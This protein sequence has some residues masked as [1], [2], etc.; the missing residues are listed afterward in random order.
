MLSVLRG[1]SF[2]LLWTAGLVSVTGDWVLNAALPF[3]VYEETGSTIATAGMIVA[4]LAPTAL[5]GSVA[6]VFVDR[7]SRKRVLVWT[8]VSQAA[9][10]T[11][12]LLVPG[13][14]SL[15]V[16]FVVAA[17]QSV[18]SSFSSP[19]ESALLPALVGPDELLVANALNTLNNRIAR[20]AGVP[21]GGVLLANAGLEAVVLV[22]V[23]S[24]AAAALLVAPIAAP[25]VPRVV[26][27]ASSAW[28]SFW[29]EWLAGLHLVRNDRTI[30]LLFLVLGLMTFGG[31]M[32]DPLTVA[33]V[34]DVLGEGP[35]VFTWIL[36][37]HAAAGIAGSLLVGRFGRRFTPRDLIGWGSVVAGAALALRYNFPSVA[38]AFAMSAVAGLTSVASSTGVETL[39]M[40]SVRDELR[41]RVFGSLNATLSLLSLAGAALAGL[42]AE[43][44]GI[45]PMLNVAAALIAAAGLLV[46]GAYRARSTEV[47]R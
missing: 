31:T 43:I 42:V 10:V 40:Q 34:R 22:D 16:V 47:R 28:E 23:V 30:A 5:L 12:L 3:F 1:R 29:R 25:P 38:L 44:V 37:V 15:S 9:V 32:L 27:Q 19:A 4:R 17:A 39:A 18:A 36:T 35:E 21:L 45:V 14:G 24:F 46:L 8:N 2:A 7:W 20:L 6:G 33:W 11:L 41:G 26:V 13:D